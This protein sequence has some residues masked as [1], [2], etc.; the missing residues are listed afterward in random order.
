M[1]SGV[2]VLQV[3]MPAGAVVVAE[4]PPAEGKRQMRGDPRV[5]VK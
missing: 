2:A 4:V 3:T 5:A 1:G